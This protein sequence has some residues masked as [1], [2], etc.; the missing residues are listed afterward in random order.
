MDGDI[1]E[2]EQHVKLAFK[3]RVDERFEAVFGGIDAKGI[4]AL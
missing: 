4:L 2:L 1:P 3:Q